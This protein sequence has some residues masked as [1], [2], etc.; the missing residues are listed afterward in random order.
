MSTATCPLPH[1]SAELR[2]AVTS[3]FVVEDTITPVSDLAQR[4]SLVD[5]WEVGCT[6]G[7]VIDSGCRETDGRP[8][9]LGLRSALSLGGLR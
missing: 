1:C 7:H 5:S 8:P 3:E 2:L 4:H 9:L 6:E